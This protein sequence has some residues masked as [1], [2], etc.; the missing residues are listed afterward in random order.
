MQD[1]LTQ[2]WPWYV[3]G[4]LLGLMIPLLLVLHNKML[5][6]SSTMQHMCTALIPTKLEYFNYDWR[7]HTWTF[8]FGAGL[9]LSGLIGRL[10]LTGDVPV[11]I[12]EATKQDFNALGLTDLS[13]LMPDQIFGIEHLF[14][15]QG[16]I[17][18]V[19]GGFLVGF[20]VRYAGG[21]TAGHGFMGVSMFNTS[22]IIALISFFAGGLL[23]THFVFPYLF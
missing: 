4:P 11:A 21:C 7:K 1:F 22:S 9:V 15:L 19:L 13:G 12:S 5:G 2:P 6:V 10:F 14:S 8:W 3:S 17:F 18:M 23:V 20:G 16:F